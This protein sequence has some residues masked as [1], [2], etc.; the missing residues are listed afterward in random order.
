RLPGLVVELA[1]EAPALQLLGVDDPAEGVARDPLRE[2]DGER[3]AC[4]ER[5]GDA[6]VALGEAGVRALLVVDG[7]DADRP[8][9]HEERHPETAA[10]LEAPGYLAVDF[11]IVHDRVDSLAAAALEHAAALGAGAP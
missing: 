3:G 9:A 7:D 1:G 6:Q 11:G 10:R 2:V 5:L 4:R 8:I